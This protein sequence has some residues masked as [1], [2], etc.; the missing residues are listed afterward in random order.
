MPVCSALSQP[1][2]PTAFLPLGQFIPET[3]RQGQGQRLQPSLPPRGAL[4]GPLAVRLQGWKELYIRRCPRSRL[5]N[6]EERSSLWIHLRPQGGPRNRSPQQGLFLRKAR[7]LADSPSPPLR[8][9]TRPHPFPCF[10]CKMPTSRLLSVPSCVPGPGV[11]FWNGMGTG[12]CLLKLNFTQ[13]VFKTLLRIGF[14][15]T[16]VHM[17]VLSHFSH[18]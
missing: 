10:F 14:S 16:V 2:L 9:G 3:A 12:D 4:C 8:E 6:P 13:C 11:Q 5:I 1:G 17:C 18:V 7:G 15:L